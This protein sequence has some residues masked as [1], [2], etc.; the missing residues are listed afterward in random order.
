M[1]AR[2]VFPFAFDSARFRQREVDINLGIGEGIRHGG[3]PFHHV[4]AVGIS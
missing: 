1:R 2:I 3:F 4:L